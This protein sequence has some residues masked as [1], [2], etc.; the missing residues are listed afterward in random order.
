MRTRYRIFLLLLLAG[1]ALPLH[2]QQKQKQQAQGKPK[3]AA[4]ANPKP[5]TRAV[6]AGKKTVK[7]LANTDCIVKVD[8]EVRLRCKADEIGKIYL[9]TGKFLLEVVSIADEKMKDFRIYPV[10][11][12][13]E[14]DLIQVDLSKEKTYEMWDIQKPPRFPGGESELQKYLSQNI[15]YPPFAREHNIEG[16]VALTFVVGHDGDLRD[17]NIIKDIGGGCGKEAIRIVESMPKWIPGEAYG[18]PV[19]VNYNLS[20]RFKL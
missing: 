1:A 5:Q 20:V 19:N 4:S 6:S 18:N 9:P 15:N 17:V 13:A 12:I 7:I 16:M 10:T 14:E 8:G 3:P 11:D 2:A